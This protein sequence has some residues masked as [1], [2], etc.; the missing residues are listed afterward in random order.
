MGFPSAEDV[1]FKQVRHL[2]GLIFPKILG[3]K[4]YLNTNYPNQ[5]LNID[6]LGRGKPTLTILI[7]ELA[8]V[9]LLGE[10]RILFI[11]LHLSHC[12][13]RFI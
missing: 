12:I 13:C 10:L 11:Q 5:N 8:L 9:N 7:P 6:T 2:Q 3:G 1:C 4:G